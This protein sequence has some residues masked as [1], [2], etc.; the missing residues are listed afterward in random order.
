MVDAQF[1]S[2]IP[3]GAVEELG[4][5]ISFHFHYLRLDLETELYGSC[6]MN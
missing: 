3:T 1:F 6:S 5:Y 4:Q 2:P